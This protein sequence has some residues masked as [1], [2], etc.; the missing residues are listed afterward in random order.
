MGNVFKPLTLAACFFFLGSLHASEVSSDG[1]E[2]QQQVYIVY[3]GHEPSELAAGGG[4]SAAKA[5]HHGLLNQTTRSWDFLVFPETARRSLP[6]EVEI[7]VGM[8]DTGVWPDSPSFSDEGFGPPPSRWKGACHNFTSRS[9]APARTG[10]YTGLSPVDTAGHGTHTESTVAGRVVENVGLTG[11]AAGSARGAMPGARLAVY[12]A[13]WDDFCRSEDMLA[14]FDVAVADGVDLISFSIARMLPLPYFEDV[15]AMGGF[16]AMR[17]GVLTSPAAGNSALDGGGVDNVAPWILSI[18]ASSTDRR[19]VGKLVLGNGKTI[20]GASVNIFPKL[21]KA[22][23][24]L[25]MNIN[26]SCELE[27]L[28]GQSYKG[29]IL[30]CASAGDGMG[31]LLAGAAGAVIVTAQPNIAFLLPLPALKITEDQFAEI[32]AYVNKTRHPASIVVCNNQ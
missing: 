8:I 19:L 4:F 13:C 23:L 26:G 17:R 9:S 6:T 7:I 20:V 24:V 21:N 15:V 31:P 25:L 2:R 27:P 11:L 30:L 32:M 18:A 3:M 28:A 5:A 14:A 10:G 22:P 29:K 1:D 12:K 16:H